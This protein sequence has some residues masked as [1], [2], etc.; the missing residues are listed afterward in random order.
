[1]YQNFIIFIIIYYYYYSYNGIMKPIA[2]REIR[3]RLL[4]DY[5]EKQ[6]LSNRNR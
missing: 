2:Q 5:A 4:I 1:M 6:L 3:V